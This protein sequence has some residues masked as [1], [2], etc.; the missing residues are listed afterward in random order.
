[1][2]IS[3]ENIYGIDRKIIHILTRYGKLKSTIGDIHKSKKWKNPKVKNL[4][5]CGKVWSKSTVFTHLLCCCV[6]L[7]KSLIFSNL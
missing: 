7:I 6:S 3:V 2:N 5:N 1:M 4:S